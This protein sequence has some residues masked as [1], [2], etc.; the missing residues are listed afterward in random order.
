LFSE[1]DAYYFNTGW[2]KPRGYFGD[3]TFG[4][5]KENF[6]KF[7]DVNGLPL[8]D[9]KIDIFQ[10][11]IVLEPNAQPVDDHG[12]KYFPVVEDGN[13]GGVPTSKDPVIVGSTDQ[14][15]ILRLPNRP[16]MPV[17]TFNGFERHDNPFGNL[18]VA[19]D[20]GVMLVR[21]TK[22]NNPQY[23][24]LDNYAF[25]EAW[26]RGERDKFTIVLKT[27]YGSV[28]SPL[29]PVNV[30]FEQLD[31]NHVKVT[32]NAPKV[33]REQ[34]YLDRVI[35]YKVYRRIGPMGLNDRPWFPVATLNPDTTEFTID[36]TL[37]PYDVEWFS[38]TN[39]FA[40]SSLGETSMESELVEAPMPQPAK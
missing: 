3:Y 7:V 28:S 37:K 8:Q 30:K 18:N 24:W 29:A 5:P 35:G 16:A 31:P 32:W 10:R 1:V 38:S 21:V 33:I 11:G 19:G 13:W 15:G 34:Q 27:S 2:D 4:I 20:R 39:R 22:N 40:V 36:L 26:V 12:V 23:F 9:A 14:N 6:L 25:N 17:R